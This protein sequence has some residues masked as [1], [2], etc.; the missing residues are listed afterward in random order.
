MVGPRQ[1]TGFVFGGSLLVL[2]CT[3]VLIW[4]PGPQLVG[5][6]PVSTS[7]EARYQAFV[8]FRSADCDGNLSFAQ[9]FERPRYR[10]SFRLMG[11]VLDA[12]P[13]EPDLRSKLRRSGVKMRV[14]G[15]NRGLRRS[16]ASVSN[17]SGPHLVIVDR[18]GRLR[19]VTVTPK[20]P[21]EMHQFI[22][23]L[24]SYTAAAQ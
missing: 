17:E 11:I 1:Q 14:V 2:L 15:A 9:V 18:G 16:I 5:S 4:A 20:T 12:E 13:D 6:L 8:V 24:N 3:G 7:Q 23:L 22:A 21:A 10:S 19:T